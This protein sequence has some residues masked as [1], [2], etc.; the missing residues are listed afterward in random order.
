M[1]RKFKT[2][3]IQ[4][5]ERKNAN[6]EKSPGPVKGYLMSLAYCLLPT[7]IGVMGNGGNKFQIYNLQFRVNF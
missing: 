2:Q 6:R 1:S 4:G 5:F 7:A 3:G